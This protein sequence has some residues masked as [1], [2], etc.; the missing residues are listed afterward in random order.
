MTDGL[1]WEMLGWC[2]EVLINHYDSGMT[3]NM[4]CIRMGSAGRCWVRNGKC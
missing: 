1:E 2:G 3:V 4:D